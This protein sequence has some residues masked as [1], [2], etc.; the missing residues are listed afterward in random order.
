MKT[1]KKAFKPVGIPR[2][3]LECLV[4]GLVLRGELGLLKMDLQSGIFYN[5]TLFISTLI[6][7]WMMLRLRIV[8]GKWGRKIG[9][10]LLAGFLLTLLTSLVI[11]SFFALIGRSL[12][13]TPIGLFSLLAMV[14]GP[15]FV[16]FRA[17]R[18]FWEWWQR[19]RQHKLIWELIHI[20]LSLAGLIAILFIVTGEI[21]LI[22]SS[23]PPL[24]IEGEGLVMAVTSRLMETILPYLGITILLTL[25]ML[26]ILLAPAALVSY[27]SV[28]RLTNRLG[29][30]ADATQRL[31]QGDYQARAEVQGADEIAQLQQDFNGMAEDL[32]YAFGALSEERDK[33]EWLLEDRRQLTAN[34]SHEL[35]TPVATIQSYLDSLS[36][37][38]GLPESVQSDLNILQNEVHHLTRLIDDLFTLSQAEVGALEIVSEP[39]EI[40]SL[41]RQVAGV[42]RPLA[43]QSGKVVL[44]VE[45]ESDPIIAV[46][47]DRME[48]VLANLIRNAI[49]HTPPGGIISLQ[50]REEGQEVKLH[51]RDTGEGI[52]EEDLP[53]IWE[54]FYRGEEARASGHRG[55]GLGLSLVRELVSEM[56]G[57]ISVL[58]QPGMGTEF[59]MS[60]NLRQGDQR[61]TKPQQV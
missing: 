8:D 7:F 14:S 23:Y 16:V 10:D 34:T 37:R 25:G 48:Q 18:Y 1:R 2:A 9:F 32:E 45:A 5:A 20:Q 50:V 24:D 36:E 42:F 44:V 49:H 3:L 56:G 39:V 57:E 12:M 35:R 46:D 60:F 27:L 28:R 40:A 29:H 15:L 6:A 41:V 21:F 30:L 47:P 33:V 53:H 26:V 13:D 55:A 22:L 43:W 19:K 11:P 31:R 54:R 59:I 4:L 51:I 52:S 38:E 17:G 58:S 61:E